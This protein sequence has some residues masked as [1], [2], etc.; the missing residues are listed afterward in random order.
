MADYDPVLP[1]N[2][3]KI[4]LEKS[5]IEEITKMQDH[6]PELISTVVVDKSLIKIE[7][8]G[9]LKVYSTKVRYCY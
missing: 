7:N 8:Y 1:D 3:I 5:G 4:I 9:Y 2:L 6:Y